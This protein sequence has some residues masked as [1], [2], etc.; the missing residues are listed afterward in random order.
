MKAKELKEITEK[1]IENLEV[2]IF[3]KEDDRW[4]AY[5]TVILGGI[6]EV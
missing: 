5:A 3:L 6:I 4:L 2:K 1:V